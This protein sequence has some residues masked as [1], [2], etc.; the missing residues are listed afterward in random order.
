MKKFLQRLFKFLAYLAA[1]VVILLAVAVGLFRLFLPRLP[2]YQDEIK[3]WAS[4]AI[5][6]QVEFSG[7]DARWGLSGPQLEFYDA[8]LIRPATMTRVVAADQVSVGVALSRLLMD[9]TL[10]VDRL[11]IRDTSVEVRQLPNGRWWIQGT[12]YEDLVVIQ[13]GGGNLGDV[14]VIAESVELQVIRPGDERPLF[15]DVDRAA[16]SSDEQRLAVDATI[17][18]PESLGRRLEISATQLPGDEETDRGWDV[19]VEASDLIL[20]GVA[21]MD[22]TRRWPISSGT[23]NLDA[24]F[25]W[26]AGKVAS[27]VAE[28]EF[29]EITLDSRTEFS[30]VGRVEFRQDQDGWLVAADGFR[31]ST[32]DGTWPETSLRL[33]TGADNDGNIVMLDASGDYINLRDLNLFAPLLDEERRFTVDVLAADGIVRNLVATLSDID[34]STPRYAISA[35]LERVGFSADG[36]R[37]GLRGFSGRLR[38]DRSGGRL[39]IQSQDMS[40]E[41]TNY[42]RDPIP[43]YDASGT[44][45]WRRSGE[46]IT[47]LSDNITIRND[48]FDSQSNIQVTLESGKSPVV[49]L[50]SSWSMTDIGSAKRFIPSGVMVPKLYEWFQRALVSGY[51][52]RGTTRLYGPL[53]KFPF[54]DGE[55][56]FLLEANVRNM[57]FQFLP[58][59]P[60]AEIIDMDVV[61]D[62]TRLYSTQNRSINRGRE[63]VDANVEIGDLRKPV[64][65]I[66]SFSTGS[67]ESLHTYAQ[68]SPIGRVFGGNLGRVRVAGEGTFKLDLTVPIADWRNFTFSARIVSTDGRLEV[69][70]FNPPITGLTGA[71]TL[72]R[73]SVSSEALGGQFLG[74]AVSIDVMNAPEELSEFQVLARA[75]GKAESR[76]LIEELG[77]PVEGLINGQAEYTVDLLF[78]KRGNDEPVPFTVNVESDLVGLAVNVPSPFLKPADQPANVSGDIRFMPGGQR[79]ESR[80]T[81]DGG[82]SWQ[83]AFTHDTQAWDLERGTLALGGAEV[84]PAETRGLHIR[85]N[86]DNIRLDDWLRLSRGNEAR[87]GTAERIRS[88]E[89]D[90]D[91]LRILGQHL[92]EH[93][94]RVDRSARDWLVQF[95]GEH[96]SGSVFVPYDFSSDR[97]LVME[98]ER[99]VLPGD[100]EKTVAAAEQPD[101][102][103]LPPIRL[104]TQEFGLGKRLFGA[105]DVEFA[106]TPDG[107]VAD[108]FVA[109]DETFEI[110][111]NARW[112]AVPTDPNGHRS[113]LMATLTSTDV[114]TTMQRLDYQPG[115]VSDDMSILFDLNWSG[116]PRTEIF[117][118]LNGD[119]QVR[120]GAGQLDEIEPGAGRLF[121]LMSI[122]ALPRR[123]S[124]DFTDVFDKGFGFD[125]IEGS[126]HIVDGEAYTC[127]LTLGGPAA[128]IAIVGRA[129]L[130]DREYEQAA[131]V[132]AN[133][134]NSLP[135]VGAVG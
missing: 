26:S 97:V 101:P 92:R 99:L 134:G 8:E 89:V 22:R 14:E 6:M 59:W 57:T 64:L 62:N 45:I 34:T 74:Q 125:S 98:M 90:V 114:M 20:P 29:D 135:V 132:S 73:K 17:L 112:V 123:L 127:N 68:D 43:I 120:F 32:V 71:V 100:E 44:V 82:V 35:D 12:P 33:E 66:D 46:L 84:S 63:V 58:D 11:V 122:V 105:V 24:S 83:V 4:N 10:V 53:D 102:R 1:G 116:G 47:V 129:S 119:V 28:F 81:A 54:D 27:A 48:D 38:A 30:M 13:T 95:E 111:G 91:S 85:G 41:L 121:G 65:T 109:Q 39:E 76:A 79:I 51:I 31:L 56:R 118:S 93:R 7:M 9:R 113:Y 87:S 19:A 72:D 42:L 94:V 5:G 78:P 23:G 70:G 16:L 107:L 55:G 3:A 128:D 77:L 67:L 80:G 130:T 104:T 88:I 117:S 50:E 110:V 96:V 18:L 49:D 69:S 108:T 131:V 61:L 126:F 25:A 40:L 103:T 21:A 2:E 106:R 115:I 124:L 86:I 36:N 133:F 75:R 37:P 60:A 15:F 52:P